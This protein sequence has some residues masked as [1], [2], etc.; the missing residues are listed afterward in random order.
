MFNT[1][2]SAF[3]WS[4]QEKSVWASRKKLFDEFKISKHDILSKPTSKGG[5]KLLYTKWRHL[6]W[7]QEREFMMILMMADSIATAHRDTIKSPDG[8]PLDKWRYITDN[9]SGDPGGPPSLNP[10]G[11]LLA[12]I[13]DR[14]HRGVFT[15][16]YIPK[17]QESMPWLLLADNLAGYLNGI[18][19]KMFTTEVPRFG[20][21]DQ[22]PLQWNWTDEEFQAYQITGPK[23]KPPW[24]TTG[25]GK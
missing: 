3:A 9:I 16:S 5:T 7:I 13:L 4:F 20:D 2:I 12:K 10:R 8:M 17:E 6:G 25:V 15:V 19:N 18:L 22:K 11:F 14:R 21:P 1:N 24:Q 23:R